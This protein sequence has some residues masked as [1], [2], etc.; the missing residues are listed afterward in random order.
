MSED[1]NLYYVVEDRTNV[2]ILK[3]SAWKMETNL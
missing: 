2:V 1:D 3:K